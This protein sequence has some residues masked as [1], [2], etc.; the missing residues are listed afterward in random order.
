MVPVW[1]DAFAM[2]SIKLT[3][4]LDEQTASRLRSASERLGIAQSQVVR[5]AIADYAARIG[6][7]SERER[8]RMLAT[9]DELVAKIPPRPP[10]E[11]TAETAE[12]RRLR[13]AGGRR[14]ARRPRSNRSRGRA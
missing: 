5:E 8:L 2:A 14:E 10:A 6:R 7:L 9:F 3:F 13:R 11:V 4:S 1:Y 12:I